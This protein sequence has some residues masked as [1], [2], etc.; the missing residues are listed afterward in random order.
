MLKIRSV[1]TSSTCLF[2]YFF[3]FYLKILWKKESSTPRNT[4]FNQ[5]YSSS[6]KRKKAAKRCSVENKRPGR[7]HW[8]AG[9]VCSLHVGLMDLVHIVRVYDFKFQSMVRMEGKDDYGYSFLV[10]CHVTFWHFSL[11]YSLYRGV[12]T[13]FIGETWIEESL[14]LFYLHCYSVEVFYST[15][16]AYCTVSTVLYC[17]Y[18]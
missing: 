1:R 16:L 5:K 11:L 17:Q 12:S 8:P 10:P 15:V 2:A 18:M 13:F 4:V 3:F 14:K 9:S 7:P 6:W